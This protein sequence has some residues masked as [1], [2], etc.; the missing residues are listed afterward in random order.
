MRIETADFFFQQPIDF[1]HKKWLLL[2]FIRDIKID[3]NNYILYPTLDQIKYQIQ[4]LEKW[5]YTR[6]LYIK[7]KLKGLDFEK[8]TLIYDIP[9]DSEEIKEINQIVDYSIDELEPIYRFGAKIFRQIESKIKWDRVG[10]MPNYKEEGYLILEIESD[11]L[12]YEYKILLGNVKLALVDKRTKNFYNTPEKI[13]LDLILN[14]KELPNP[15]T[16]LAKSSNYPLDETI[17]PII[18]RNLTSK[19]F[20]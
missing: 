2:S 18:Q 5:K 8:M 15:N 19:I 12:I 7:K 13:K 10:I 6:E 1:E 3:F 11:M 9:E 20:I 14:R 17:V 16:I 4:N